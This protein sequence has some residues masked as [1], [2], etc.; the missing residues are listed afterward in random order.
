MP[1]CWNSEFVPSEKIFI[2]DIENQEFHIYKKAYPNLFEDNKA[3]IALSFVKGGTHLLFKTLEL[4][5]NTPP[6]LLIY[7]D[8][9]A[10]NPEYYFKNC[11]KWLLFAHFFSVLNSISDHPSNNY[12]KILLIRDPRD[13]IIST[14]HWLHWVHANITDHP[15]YG[16]IVIDEFIKLKPQ[17]Q[18]TEIIRM[19]DQFE[20]THFAENMRL[21]S[22]N[23]LLWMKNPS[24]L[25]LRFEDLVGVKGGG[26]LDRQKD[27]IR[28]LAEYIQY[29]LSNAQIDCIANSLFGETATFRKGQIGSWQENFSDYHKEIF[30]QIMGKELIELGYEQDNNW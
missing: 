25:L 28:S 8:A 3:I 22:Q 30:K 29:P 21:M 9:F 13:V 17:D 11:G 23:A 5:T 26:D 15:M 10:Q 27:T 1:S 16:P 4:I 24:T 20:S 19:P 12:S 2:S 14:V 6:S 7:Y 18:I